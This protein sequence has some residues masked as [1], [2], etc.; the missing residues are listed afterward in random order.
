MQSIVFT[1]SFPARRVFIQYGEMFMVP[2]TTEWRSSTSYDF[3][4]EVDTDSLA[5]ECL[6][7]NTAY[8]RDFSETLLLDDV[9]STKAETIRNRW[10]LRFPRP[11]QP[12][13]PRTIGILDS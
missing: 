3:M 12:Q 5:W 6:R 8:Q 13:R 10:G 2:D 7:R 1:E 11:P 9:G 4:D